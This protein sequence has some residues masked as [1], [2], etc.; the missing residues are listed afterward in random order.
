[1]HAT[2]SS[3]GSPQQVKFEEITESSQDAPPR[4]FDRLVAITIQ[5]GGLFG[6]S[7]LGQL[8]A[9]DKRRFRPIAIAGTSAGAIVAALYWAGLRPA[10]IREEVVSLAERPAII[11]RSGTGLTDLMG[12]FEPR[13]RPFDFPS[14]RKTRAWFKHVIFD[15]LREH[16]RTH[17]NPPPDSRWGRV[18]R[19]IQFINN[20]P[21]LF[22]RCVE[23]PQMISQVRSHIVN[24]GLFRGSI[25]E[26]EMD[27]MLRTSRFLREYERE[28][29]PPGTPLCFRHFRQLA[30]RHPGMP[31]FQPLILTG[32]NITTRR[33]DLFNSMDDACLEVPVARAVRASAGFPVA[34]RPIDIPEGPGAD[35]YVD[36]GVISNFPAWVFNHEFRRRLATHPDY[37]GLAFR[38]W[39]HVGLRLVDDTTR[40]RNLVS[41]G[42]FIRSMLA[43]LLG[44]ARNDLEERVANMIS[45][46]LTIKQPLSETEGPENLLDFDRM[47]RAQI[48]AMFNR[49]ERY[50]DHS[51]QNVSFALPATRSILPF[52]RDLIEQ[53]QLLFTGNEEVDFRFRSNIFV[54]RGKDLVLAYQVN[55][56]GDPDCNLVLGFNQG[57]TGFCFTRRLPLVCN[58]QNFDE[59]VRLGHYT[60]EQLFGF[61]PP[62]QALI[63]MDRTWMASVPIFDP[64]ASYPLE[65]S[66]VQSSQSNVE[67]QEYASLPGTL[68]GAVFGV[69]NLD[70]ALNYEKIGL[71][72]NVER[73]WQDPRVRGTVRIMR[74]VA[75]EVGRLFSTAFGTR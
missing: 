49:G 18:D 5:G 72:K 20:L 50:A 75:S 42:E 9:L 22:L 33:L 32:T 35:W 45:R 52:L 21:G 16:V 7:L 19:F 64:Y 41:P 59:L 46:S 44:Q 11:G 38:P 30:K 28:L 2:P 34:F 74:S 66:E 17:S 51:L 31:F 57:L 6:L 13:Y 67:G 71:N 55:M 53:V 62:T 54:P 24:R 27:R 3:L 69:L 73:H 65:L 70:A 40:S 15:P 48:E 8:E 25:L 36:G 10:Q 39:L 12:H 23:A 68:D 63:R 26:S 43:L 58:L 4:E 61:D 47:H 56:D 1:L 29:P 60:R 14:Y 37:Q